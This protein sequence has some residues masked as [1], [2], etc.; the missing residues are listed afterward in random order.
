MGNF[1][2]FCF[3]VVQLGGSAAAGADQTRHQGLAQEL[4]AGQRGAS[5]GESKGIWVKKCPKVP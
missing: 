3:S 2:R 1:G 5:A 4:R